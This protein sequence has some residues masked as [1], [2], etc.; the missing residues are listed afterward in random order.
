MYEV[1]DRFRAAI[2]TDH[3]V[4]SNV[5]ILRN[6]ETVA[7]LACTPLVAGSAQTAGSAGEVDVDGTATTVRSCTV[8]V[9]DPTD[10]LTPQSASDLL[11]PF[12]TEA[13][14]WR[15]VAY[16]DGTSETVPLGTF[17]LSR[18]D[19]TNGPVGLTGYD[20]ST[21]VQGPSAGPVP[22][23]AGMAVEDA[24]AKIVASKYPAAQFHLAVTGYTTPAL[25]VHPGDDVWQSAV[26]LAL[27]AGYTLAC[28]RMGVFVMRPI[29]ASPQ[30][31]AEFVEGDGSTFWS[32]LRSFDASGLVN[33]VIV[34]GTHS[35]TGGTVSGSAAD[36]NPLSPTYINGPY[37]QFTKTVQS[38]VVA[39]SG[40]ATAMA[41]ALL[42][43]QLG[44][45][46]STT[47]TALVD[48]TLDEGDVV[49]LTS[50]RLGLSGERLIVSKLTVPMLGS[51]SMAVTAVKTLLASNNTTIP[52]V[53]GNGLN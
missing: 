10:T 14:L 6:G 9:C 15:G 17:R 37:G 53:G 16:P 46:E 21:V 19:V 50:S 36:T 43:Q 4:T 20:R 32:P 5:E 18:T 23:P 52:V 29:V 35:S 34:Q 12:G 22:I 47:L 27:S 30:P 13:R 28:D 44:L 26:K 49:T 7:N 11:M 38:E 33:E 31:A 25:L 48:V 1:S 8:T 24:I 2:V 45:T 41:Q 3:T 40:Q 51:G 39:T 42:A